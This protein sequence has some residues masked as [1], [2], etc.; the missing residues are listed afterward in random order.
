MSEKNRPKGRVFYLDYENAALTGANGCDR[1]NKNDKII[2]FIPG[3]EKSISGNSAKA[4]IGT[5]AKIRFVNVKVGKTNAL[6]F[7][8]VMY[9]GLKYKKDR[10][11]YIIS[12]DKGYDY[13]VN[14]CIELGFEN[15]HRYSNI[16]DAVDGVDNIANIATEKLRIINRKKSAYQSFCLMLKN[17]CGIEQNE[18]VYKDIFNAVD[19]AKNKLEC[20]RILRKKYKSLNNKCEL[21]DKIK[22][23]YD[24]IFALVQKNKELAESR[25]CYILKYECELPYDEEIYADINKALVETNDKNEFYHFLLGKYGQKTNTVPFYEKIKNKYIA[26]KKAADAQG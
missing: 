17:K 5:K 3:G 24:D 23:R 8:L 13:A 2:I 12:N 7:Q 16:S 10:E 18:T 9:I 21:Y 19:S 11:H 26:L 1:L 25:V 4:F 14:M 20:F 15:V 6:D 22:D